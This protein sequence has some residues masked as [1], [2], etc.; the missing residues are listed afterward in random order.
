MPNITIEGADDFQQEVVFSSSAGVVMRD[1]VWQ[2]IVDVAEAAREDIKRN[3]PVDYGDAQGRWGNP[4]WRMLNPRYQGAAG[5]GI[6]R[7]D[8]RNLTHTQGAELSPFEY[9]ERLN[10]GS[11]QQAPAGF[12]DAAVERAIDKAEDSTLSA[13]VGVWDKGV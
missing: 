1:K 3:M 6:W 10:E 8:V 4:Q 11:S 9:I 13:V 2:A 7:E 12:I 5:Q